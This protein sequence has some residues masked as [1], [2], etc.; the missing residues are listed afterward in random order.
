MRRMN[1]VFTLPIETD[2]LVRDIAYGLLDTADES[3]IAHAI[4]HVD[5]LADALEIL[6]DAVLSKKAEDSIN[7]QII[8]AA[9]AL[10]KYRGD[11]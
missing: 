8:A 3:A 4:N 10:S 2:M 11:K 6:L 7:N 5:S 1:E 9:Q